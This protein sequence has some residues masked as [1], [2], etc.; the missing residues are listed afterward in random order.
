MVVA[1][2]FFI[3]TSREKPK[4]TIVINCFYVNSMA[5]GPEFIFVDPTEHRQQNNK[6]NTILNEIRAQQVS[7]ESVQ[8]L[9]PVNKN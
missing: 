6:P 9:K 4:E 7:T 5:R 8:L 1:G 2:D 3:A